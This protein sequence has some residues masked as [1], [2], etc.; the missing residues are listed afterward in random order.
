MAL[1]TTTT[2]TLSQRTQWLAAAY[3]L[4]QNLPQAAARKLDFNVNLPTATDI[5]LDLVGLLT[6]IGKP[7]WFLAKF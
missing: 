5:Q 7:I 3:V 6:V 2:T 4:L 1:T